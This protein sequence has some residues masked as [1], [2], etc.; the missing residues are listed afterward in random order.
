M[1]PT[2]RETSDVAVGERIQA[3]STSLSW[4]DQYDKTEA[5][6]AAEDG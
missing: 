5:L 2:A 6:Y 1:V 3:G 4:T